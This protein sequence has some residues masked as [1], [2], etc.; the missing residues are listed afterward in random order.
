MAGR[1]DPEIKDV[2]EATGVTTRRFWTMLGIV[3]S[4][5]AAKATAIVRPT[6]RLRDRKSGKAY[7]LGPVELPVAWPAWGDVVIQG[8]L[9][10]GDEVEI[11]TGDASYRAWFLDG[12]V[13]DSQG[14]GRKIGDAWCSP[15]ALSIGRRATV[16]SGEV[17]LG[18]RTGA[19]TVIITV[20]GAG[21]V[22]VQ[23]PSVVL[24]AEPTPKLAVA[25]DG[26]PV[27][28]SAA[29]TTWRTSV[30]AGILAAGG[31]VVVPLVGA[32]GEVQATSAEVSSG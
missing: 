27:T 21:E 23:A 13:T 24:G 2:I 30:E 7:E 6:P 15:V 16:P 5:D 4:Y 1:D 28:S 12:G 25:R 3:D 31:G 29:F 20:T 11:T 8:E 17:Y 10:K 26:D 22:R 32:T 18:R 19:A 14:P 9:S